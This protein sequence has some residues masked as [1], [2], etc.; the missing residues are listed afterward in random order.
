MYRTLP[1]PEPEIEALPPFEIQAQ[2]TLLQVLG[3]LASWT[4]RSRYIDALGVD[5][6]V[7]T[8]EAMSKL[9]GPDET[10]RLVRW[11]LHLRVAR[12]D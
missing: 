8:R 3:F 9:W 10:P 1:F 11:P 2:W 5:P 7:E 4:G 6:L 12:F